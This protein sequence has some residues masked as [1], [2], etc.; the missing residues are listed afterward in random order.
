MDRD[1]TGSKTST[2]KTLGASNHS[3]SERVTRDYYA[4]PPIAVE[5][6]LKA[7]KFS[8]KILEPCC[9]E[10]HISKVLE[11]HGYKVSSYDLI[12][13]GFGIGGED[14]LQRTKKFKGDIITNPPYRQAKEFVEKSLELIPKGNKVAMLLKLQFLES[15]GREALFDKSPP[16]EVLVFTS[17]IKCGPNGDFGSTRGAVAYAWFIWEKGFEGDPIIKWIY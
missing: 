16:K 7:C 3:K 15:K 11:K 8:K 14:Y 10:G 12:D 1:W 17:R 13:R 4:T 6:L 5:E 9:G 2:W